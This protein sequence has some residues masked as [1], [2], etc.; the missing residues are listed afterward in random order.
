MVRASS[1]RSARCRL[2]YAAG[3]PS[4]VLVRRSR[5]AGNPGSGGFS[6]NDEIAPLA[7]RLGLVHALH[8][9][10]WEKTRANNESGGWLER[11]E[12]LW[13]R[14]DATAILKTIADRSPDDRL[15]LSDDHLVELRDLIDEVDEPEPSLL[16]RVG[17]AIAIEAYHWVDDEQ[18]FEKE[19]V[20]SLYLPAAI[21][22][23][24]DGWPKVASSTPG[25]SWAVPRYANLL[26]PGDRRSGKSG[27]RRFLGRLGA[28]NVSA[29]FISPIE[30]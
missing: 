16:L 18:V 6:I 7:A 19:V 22:G 27:A 5:E 2:R 8:D 3:N 10:C 11:L 9:S 24:G 1:V 20:G 4:C 30:R 17:Q 25:L 21:E 13:Q 23:E 15:E 26:N 14:L 12:R 28:S 29:S